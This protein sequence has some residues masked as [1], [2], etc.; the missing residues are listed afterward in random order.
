MGARRSKVTKFPPESRTTRS[1]GVGTRLK[2]IDNSGAKICQI[3]AVIG[4]KGRRRRSAAASVGDQVLVTVKVG[5][6]EVRK[7]MFKAIV[8]STRKE[9][10]RS[11]GLR[12][13]F[14]QN[15][16]I[17]VDD[18][19]GPKGSEVKAVVAKEAVERW[20]AIGKIAGVVV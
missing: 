4:Y 20:A 15:G 8:T 12:V 9:I 17:L 16:C 18:D 11:N 2:C 13:K 1:V 19:G 10:K 5:K 14:E 7:K 6:P 3:I